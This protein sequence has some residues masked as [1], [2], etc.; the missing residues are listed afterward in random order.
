MTSTALRWLWNGSMLI[1]VCV[2]L[3][4][5]DKNMILGGVNGLIGFA[6]GARLWDEV[7]R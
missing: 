5:G 3:Y 7:K 1:S 4:V 2:G 6:L